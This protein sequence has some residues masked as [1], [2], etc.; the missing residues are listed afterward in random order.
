MP[1]FENFIHITQHYVKFIFCSF[2]FYLLFYITFFELFSTKLIFNE[3]IIEYR[4]CL[5]GCYHFYNS[6]F[7]PVP[8]YKIP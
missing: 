5:F 6:A 3:N 7:Y 4:L 8:F 2:S 1:Y